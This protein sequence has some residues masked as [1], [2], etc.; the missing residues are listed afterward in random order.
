MKE[1]FIQNEIWVLVIGAAFGRAKVYKQEASDEAKKELKNRLREV[2]EGDLLPL[3]KK[4]MDSDDNH[5]EN[6]SRLV[7]TS[8]KYSG[9]LNG[10]KLRF[11]VAQKL[12]NLYL[13]YQWCLNQDMPAP[14]HFPVDRIIQKLS[15]VKPIVSWTKLDCSKEYMEIINRVREK[16]KDQASVAQY[17]LEVFQRQQYL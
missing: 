5:L 10:G 6:I 16:V 17:E 14:P 12:L 8:E 15:G 1:K 9:I 13:K 11:G 2:V 3:Y 4:G 7:K